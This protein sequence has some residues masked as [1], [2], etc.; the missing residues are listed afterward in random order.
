MSELLGSIWWLIV[1]LGVLVT[2]HEF[3]HYWVARRCGVRVLRFSVGFGRPLWSRRGRDGTEYVVA[4][5]P[6]GGYVK[7]LDER[8]GDV[9]DGQLDQAGFARACAGRGEVDPRRVVVVDD[10]R[11]ARPVHRIRRAER[12]AL[13]GHRAVQ[14]EDGMV[15]TGDGADP[16][17]AARAR[18]G[19]AQGGHVRG[20]RRGA[21][22]IHTH[23][24]QPDHGGVSALARFRA[25]RAESNGTQSRNDVHSHLASV[26]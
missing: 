24:R 1:S 14:S 26:G 12:H 22:H 21:R 8:E 25:Q 20:H 5:I 13:H 7:M 23:H 16:A 17:R 4:A 19:E 18:R 15:Q 10:L 9:P 2:F 3:G 11:E 6:L